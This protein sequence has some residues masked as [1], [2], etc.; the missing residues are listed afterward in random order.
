[1]CGGRYM[2]SK[3]RFNINYGDIRNAQVVVHWSLVAGGW[4]LAAMGWDGNR[5][6]IWMPTG[7]SRSM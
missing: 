5:S 2:N 3:R 1:M 4:R 6:G 7:I